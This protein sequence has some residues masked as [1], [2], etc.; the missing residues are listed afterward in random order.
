ME[1]RI[2]AVLLHGSTEL[3]VGLKFALEG[4]SIETTQVRTCEEV[5]QLLSGPVPPRLVFTGATLPD[6]SWKEVVEAAAEA[7]AP[8]S[9]IV[10]NRIPDHRLYMDAMYHGACDFITPPFEGLKHIVASAIRNVPRA[11]VGT[12]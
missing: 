8:A 5:R 6:G 12:C 2:P 1:N 3:F 11:A 9:V 4:L 7:K 10:V